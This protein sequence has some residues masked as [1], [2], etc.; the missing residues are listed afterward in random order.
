MMQQATRIEEYTIHIL[1]KAG[2]AVAEWAIYEELDQ[3]KISDDCEH[4]GVII[5][6]LVSQGKIEQM[7]IRHPLGYDLHSYRLL[8][9]PSMSAAMI[10]ALLRQRMEKEL[11]Q[12]DQYE[13]LKHKPNTVQSPEVFAILNDSIKWHTGRYN[14]LQQVLEEVK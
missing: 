7:C 14:A 6:S 10:V 3:V 2:R 8:P 5:Q 11:K 13:Q 9:E 4:I 1:Q 12:A